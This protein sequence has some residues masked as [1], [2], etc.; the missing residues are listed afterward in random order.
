VPRPAAVRI[1]DDFASG[2]STVAVRPA[3]LE[4]ARGVDVIR[5]L[6]AHQLFRQQRLDDPLDHEL[7]NFRLAHFGRVLGRDDNRINPHGFMPLILHRDLALAIGRS[8]S[9]SLFLR[10]SVSR[11]RI[12]WASWIGSGINSGVSLQA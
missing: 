11:L 6:T 12:W 5:N 10:A 7:A 9:T 3:D 8:Q 4:S 2:Q 1:D